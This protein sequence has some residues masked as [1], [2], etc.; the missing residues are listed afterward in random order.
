MMRDLRVPKVNDSDVLRPPRYTV[1]HS[2][3]GTIDSGK[4]TA[5][6]TRMHMEQEFLGIYTGP[7]AASSE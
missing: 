5:E 4:S 6:V 2:V 1:S 3:F 7:D